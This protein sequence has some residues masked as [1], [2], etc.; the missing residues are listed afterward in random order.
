MKVRARASTMLS[1]IAT[2]PS[3]DAIITTLAKRT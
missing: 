1:E 2:V 3:G